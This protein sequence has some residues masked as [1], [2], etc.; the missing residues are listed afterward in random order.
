MTLCNI[1][2]VISNSSYDVCTN[3][4]QSSHT[5]QPEY[6]RSMKADFALIFNTFTS[7]I[8]S[9]NDLDNRNVKLFAEDLTDA[10][11]SNV[12]LWF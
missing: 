10:V 7:D 8:D 2:I 1:S 5:N 9:L 6:F 11:H 3:N 12:D 4:T